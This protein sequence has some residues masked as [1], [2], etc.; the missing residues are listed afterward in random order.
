[1]NEALFQVG[2]Q[3]V[4]DME[5]ADAHFLRGIQIDIAVD[6]AQAEHVWSSKYEPS[7]QRYTSQANVFLP[8][9]QIW[10]HIE[11]GI[12]VGPLRVAD[13]LP[14]YPDI[15]CAVAAVEMQEHLFI[16]QSCPI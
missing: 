14:V 2:T 10:G 6:T 7:L 13:L 3:L 4:A 15:Q 16:R 1:M 12:I 11:F 9:F 5:I 8:F